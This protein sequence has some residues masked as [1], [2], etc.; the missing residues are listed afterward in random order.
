MTYT[1]ASLESDLDDL[2]GWDE[3]SRGFAKRRIMEAFNTLTSESSV[4]AGY[5][6]Q[7]D[8]LAERL[9]EAEIARKEAEHRSGAYERRL[10]ELVDYNT[11]LLE[12]NIKL[13]EEV[14]ELEFGPTTPD[15]PLCK[16]NKSTK[17][18]DGEA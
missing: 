4:L 3:A 14:T 8:A 11:E 2:K 17:E 15:A 13:L 6:R 10:R 9:A 5:K 1:T 16:C 7:V 12:E 18:S